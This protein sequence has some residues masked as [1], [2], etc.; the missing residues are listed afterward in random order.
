MYVLIGGGGLIGLTL[1]QNLVN[2]G[3]TV[4]V[5]DIDPGACRDARDRLGVMA[6]EG[7]AVTTEILIE[8]GIRKADAICAVLRYDALNLAMVSLARHYNVPHIISRM[9]HRDFEQPLRHA[10][11]HRIISTVDL[12]VSTMINAVEYPQV[13]SMMHF[14]QGQIEVLKLSIPKDSSVVGLKISQIAQASEF[15]SNSL[16]IGYQPH[17]HMNLIV[18]NGDTVLE[19]GS[20]VLVVTQ[21]EYLHQ[22]INFL[23]HCPTVQ[24]F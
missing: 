23:Q 16:I 10:G 6:F 11:A 8:A 7:S 17:P 3:H 5:I 4:A 22:I 1:A 21:P 12:A 19:G 24:A 15:P 14:E 9:R 18:P 13:E 2:L 20:T